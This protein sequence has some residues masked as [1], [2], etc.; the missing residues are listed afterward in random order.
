MN[1]DSIFKFKVDSYPGTVLKITDPINERPL[2]SP[3]I[4]TFQIKQEPLPKPRFCDF[5][6][7]EHNH[8]M[9]IRK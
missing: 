3:K 1:N 7:G 6:T 4:E 5:L 9:F 8:S 2:C